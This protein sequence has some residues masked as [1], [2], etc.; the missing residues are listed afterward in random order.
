MSTCA[1]PRL[2]YVVSSEITVLAFLKGHIAAA[3][4]DYDV[5]VV[6]NLDDGEFLRRLGLKAALHRIGIV[7]KI[8]L[9]RDFRALLALARLFRSER[10]VIVHSISP[11]AGLLAMFG[12]RLA[13]V[14]HR[15]HTFTGQVWV[16]RHGWRRWLLK[17]ADRLLA[18]LTTRALV[19]S[20]SQ[21]D[22]LVAERVVAPGKVEVI[23]KGSIC[24]VDGT[25]FRPDYVARHGLR[26]ELSIPPTAP[27]LLFLGRL[28]RDKGVL[29]LA[30]AFARLASSFSEAR[31][32]LVGPDEEGMADV[33]ANIC[34]AVRDRVHFVDYTSQPE[35]FMAAADV[36]CLP[37]YREG[38][39]MV[40]IEAAAEGL[41]AVAS[42]I[43]G[44]TDAVVDGQTGLLHPPG[45]VGAITEKLAE[46]LADPARRKAMGEHA[47]VRALA[48]FSQEKSSQGLLAFYAK[49]RAP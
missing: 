19:D 44:I 14:P 1:R 22:F 42:R 45:D 13:G 17:Q 33:I 29:D 3:S 11:K 38:F 12:A 2:C 16:T 36:F 30:T 25:R 41:P 21:R 24:G 28:N 10:Y 27:V 20:P 46:L 37:S 18:A 9:W 49:I 39:G 7:R 40:V 23:G 26:G 34:A 48:D 32:L 15:V 43:Y 31:L 6:A 4:V 5:S 35:R 8:S 47:R